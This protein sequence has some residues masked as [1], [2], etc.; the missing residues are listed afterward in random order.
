VTV[1]PD[2]EGAAPSPSE[3]TASSGP[4]TDAPVQG[5]TR[6]DLAIAGKII[7]QFG[8]GYDVGHSAPFWFV[9]RKGMIRIGMDGTATPADIVTNVRVLLKLR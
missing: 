8:G 4:D 9:D 7:Q 2:T 1:D 3:K 6:S 5:L